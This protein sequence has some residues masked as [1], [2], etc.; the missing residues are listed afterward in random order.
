MKFMVVMEV[1]Q[2]KEFDV[3]GQMGSKEGSGQGCPHV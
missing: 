2:D 1:E 3:E